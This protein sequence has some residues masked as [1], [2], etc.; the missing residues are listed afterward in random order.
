[1]NHHLCVFFAVASEGHRVDRDDSF[2]CYQNRLLVGESGTFLR[3]ATSCIV[4]VGVLEGVKVGSV[5]VDDLL[6][7]LLRI[8]DELVARLYLRVQGILLSQC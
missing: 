5:R 2:A 4:N 7:I 1:M 8:G 6:G 3:Q